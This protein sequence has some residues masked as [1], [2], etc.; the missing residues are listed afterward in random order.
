MHRTSNAALNKLLLLCPFIGILTLLLLPSGRATATALTQSCGKWSITASPSPG[1]MDELY[2]IV[3]I[4]PQDAWAVGRYLNAQGVSQTLIQ[5]WNDKQWSVVS[6]PSP[7]SSGNFLEGIAAISSTDIWA[8]GG[9]S[10][11]TLIEHWNGTSWNVIPSPSAGDLLGV[12]ALSS[13]DVW[14]VGA[15]AGQTLIEQWNGAQWGIVKSPNPGAYGNG[16][17]S[18]VALSPTDVWAVGDSYTT[19]FGYQALI[20]QWNGT[21]WRAVNSPSLGSYPYELR[22]IAAVAANDIWAV[23]SRT[24]APGD[25]SLTLTEHWNGTTW[26]VVSS[27]SPTGDDYLLGVAAVSTS[28]VWAVGDYSPD[29][30]NLVVQWNGTSWNVVPSPYPSGTGS[31]LSAISADSTGDVWAVGF[32]IN[33][34]NFAYHTLIEHYC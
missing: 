26:N 29:G 32:D 5:H 16:L 18:V 1:S 2:G 13:T 15:N 23:G 9:T 6:S 3:A 28:D 34:Q 30:Q 25:I 19:Q 14:A 21:R 20:E 12:S 24:A 11:S 27:P 17:N 7:G 22:A 31:S 4:S 10:S 8:V 33:N